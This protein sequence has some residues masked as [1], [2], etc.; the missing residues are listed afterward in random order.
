MRAAIAMPLLLNVSGGGRQM[1]VRVCRV[2]YLSVIQALDCVNPPL[3]AKG[4]Q[5]VRFMQHCR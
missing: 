1:S 5:D 3:I 4:S 2:D